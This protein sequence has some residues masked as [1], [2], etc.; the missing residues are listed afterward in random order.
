VHGLVLDLAQRRL[1]FTGTV[2]PE[3]TAGGSGSVTL[4][5]ELAW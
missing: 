3:F 2:L 1:R 5:G 4:Q